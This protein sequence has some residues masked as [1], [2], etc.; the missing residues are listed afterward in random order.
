MFNSLL[1]HAQI[2][3]NGDAFI[4]NRNG[5]FQTPSILG[6]EKLSVYEKS[7]LEYHE[8]TATY[9]PGSY[10]YSTRWLN[11][12]Q[13]LLVIKTK[14]E[15]SMN[16]MHWTMGYKD[17]EGVRKGTKNEIIGVTLQGDPEKARGKRG[18]KIY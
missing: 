15:D 9:S 1:L 2:G 4:I 8:G 11:D 14:V 3:P 13:W 5:Q 6:Q 16:E 12:E 10:L 17:S 7:F 18:V